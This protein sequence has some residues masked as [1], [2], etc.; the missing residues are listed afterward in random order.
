MLVTWA[1]SLPLSA[2]PTFS[3]GSFLYLHSVS[4]SSCAL[5]S[6][7]PRGSRI[8]IEALKG[9]HSSLG[10]ETCL[11][12]ST[13]AKQVELGCMGCILHMGTACGDCCSYPKYG[14]LVYYD[15]RADVGQASEEREPCECLPRPYVDWLCEPWP[16]LQL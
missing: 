10:Q 5:Q 16:S 1:T 6:A 11:S 7:P 15:V 2:S 8:P 14:Q 3:S 9:R 13:P 12:Y 4:S